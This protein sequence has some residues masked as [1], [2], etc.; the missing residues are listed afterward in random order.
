MRRPQFG[1]TT[2][3]TREVEYG[4][5]KDWVNR[6]HSQFTQ[7]ESLPS[8]RTETRPFTLVGP[9]LTY[10]KTSQKRSGEVTFNLAMI[11][12]CGGFETTGS[13]LWP[14]LTWLP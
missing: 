8:S 5:E 14:S 7:L 11:L 2:C 12:G 13:L 1:S 10:R 3:L 4:V 9:R 6:L